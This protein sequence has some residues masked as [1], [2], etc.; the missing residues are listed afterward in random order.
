MTA[1]TVLKLTTKQAKPIVQATFPAYR[2]RKFKI[3]FTTRLT[4]YDTNW[5]GGTVNKFAFVRADGAVAKLF[6]PAPWVNPIEGRTEDIP[7]DVLV[8]KHS[9]FCGED[10]GITIYAHPCHLP[11]WLPAPVTA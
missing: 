10:A 2:G 6:A 1:E 9:Y 7:E 3:V 8:V 11:K 4:F 5:S